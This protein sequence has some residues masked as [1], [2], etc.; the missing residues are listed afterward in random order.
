MMTPEQTELLYKLQLMRHPAFLPVNPVKID[1]DAAAELFR[2]NLPLLEFQNAVARTS[3]GDFVEK[4]FWGM[5]EYDCRKQIDRWLEQ[6]DYT[7][8]HRPNP[9]FGT[10]E[11]WLQYFAQPVE[12]VN[13]KSLEKHFADWEIRIPRET[14]E[15]PVPGSVPSVRKE[16]F[17]RLELAFDNADQQ[18]LFAAIDNQRKRDLAEISRITPEQRAKIKK[19]Q[20][21]GKAPVIDREE[22]LHMDKAAAE[23]YIQT[24][25]DTPEFTYESVSYEKEPTPRQ[26]PA[27][28][29]LKPTNLIG[30]RP[31]DYLQ[32]SILRD[33]I[34]EGHLATPETR[35]EL[36][37][38][39]VFITKEQAET[40][41]RPHEK[42]PAGEGLLAQC[43]QYCEFGDIHPARD[44]R[45]I[46]DVRDV[47]QHSRSFDFEAK[48]ALRDLVD[49]GCI[50]SSDAMAKIEFLS[51]EME[52]KLLAEYGNSPLGPRLRAKL[53]D[54]IADGE[55]GGMEDEY[56]QN[57]SVRQAMTIIRQTAEREN[58]RSVLP[59]TE[60]QKELLETMKRRGQLGSVQI[61][62]SRLSRR[63]AHDL[64]E[65]NMHTDIPLNGPATAKQKSL[66]K[67]LISSGELDAIP[68]SEWRELTKQRA[69]ELIGSIPDDRRSEI[70]AR[71]CGSREA[72][73]RD[74]RPQER[75]M[76]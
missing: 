28:P 68:S 22:Y 1:P 30:K 66:L 13:L 14:R 50:R 56:L 70:L 47:Y 18:K 37:E 27:Y 7:L 21:S 67:L 33:L 31:A 32:R 76:E 26:T 46:A 60:K 65:L 9:Y 49:D 55:I 25:R 62:L 72:A 40:L 17:S 16:S 43:R 39:L 8:D 58:S 10:G 74:S 36:L 42:T 44:I 3:S 54:L 15:I 45:T 35:A 61:D 2:Q 5:N 51:P 12:Q 24:Y 6:N 34:A 29:E 71:N 23:T 48:A 38:K 73:P 52:D 75:P 4:R 19:L 63:E 69:S 57:L 41:I 64:I 59:A 11:D 20:A 53:M